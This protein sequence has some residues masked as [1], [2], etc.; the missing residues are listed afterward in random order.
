MWLTLYLLFLWYTVVMNLCKVTINWFFFGQARKWNSM[1]ALKWLALKWLKSL[2]V[3]SNHSSLFRVGT[4]GV[5]V[6]LSPYL[7]LPVASSPVPHHS[8]VETQGVWVSLSPYLVLPVASS[9]VPHHSRVETQGVWVS[10]P[11]TL[12]SW[13]QF[14]CPHHSRV[15]T[16]GVSFPLP[17]PCTPCCQ[18]PCPS[19]L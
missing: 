6:S 18:F 3:S 16:R 12:R 11:F 7:V 17:V 13:F 19:P 1:E 15:E 2:L 5:W 14:P 9:P 10:H 4:V 8:R